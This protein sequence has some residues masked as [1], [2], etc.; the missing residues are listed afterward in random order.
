MTVK[1]AQT[2]FT[3]RQVIAIKPSGSGYVILCLFKEREYATWYWNG[4]AK[5][6]ADFGNY[7][8]EHEFLE[9]VENFKER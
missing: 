7:F 2:Y 1:E 5:N 9:A 4:K 3:D 6:S 8:N